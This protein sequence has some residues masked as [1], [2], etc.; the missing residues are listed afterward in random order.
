MK[1]HEIGILSFW[2]VPNYGTFAQAY[3]LQKVLQSLCPAKD[4]RHIAHLDPHHFNFYYNIKQYNREKKIWT[5][6]FWKSFLIKEQHN[7][8][9]KYLF[10][11]AYNRIPHTEE[12]DYINVQATHFEKVVLGSDIIWD[13]SLEPFNNDPMLFGDGFNSEIDSYA[14]SFGTVKLND[15]IPEYVSKS[16]QKMKYVSVRDE[17]SA[18][19]V[20]G[21]TGT[22]PAIVLDPVWLWDFEKDKSIIMPKDDN[23]IVVY[24][25]DFSESF[26]I[27]LV[28]Y[29]KAK[30]MK[31]IVL[32]CNNDQY[33]WCDVLIKQEELDPLSWIGY[34]MKAS[35]VATSTFHG[36][37]L[38]LVFNKR[39]AFC[40]SDFIIAKVGTF[41][42]ELS[43]Y[44]LF[45]YQDNV[46][47][48]LEYDW[49]YRNINSIIDKKREISINFLKKVSNNSDE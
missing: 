45:S 47:R 8:H 12:I 9:R 23:F 2:N 44:D 49:D 39:I 4:I 28:A 24:G 34:F 46:E 5:L 40:R 36:L 25:Q 1:R 11:T 20:E 21:I 18:L 35:A 13:F 42:K 16:I 31:I 10:F 29:A 37:T 6:G 22:K 33:D 48:M 38:G 26:I 7:D 43:L 32:D 41:L 15:H 27:N 30:N 14:A 3:A 19:I 17:N